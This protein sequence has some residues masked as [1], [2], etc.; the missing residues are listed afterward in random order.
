[1]FT[2]HFV[3]SL[4]TVFRP[5]WL[6]ENLYDELRYAA[7][8]GKIEWVMDVINLPYKEMQI[9]GGQVRAV[10]GFAPYVRALRRDAN[11]ESLN[12][13]C[14][15]QPFVWILFSLPIWIPSENFDGFDAVG[16][17]IQS[18]C[19][20]QLYCTATVVVAVVANTSWSKH[21]GPNICH[22]LRRCLGIHAKVQGQ[23]LWLLR[24]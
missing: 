15:L 3:H 12:K 2:F 24:N 16:L 21:F 19:C 1:M 18:V 20:R 7:I 17:E 10:T 5:C 13:C 4:Q 14:Q 8:R 11:L 6:M 22:W 23:R 9:K